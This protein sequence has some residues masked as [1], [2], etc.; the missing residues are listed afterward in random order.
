MDLILSLFMPELPLIRQQVRDHF[1]FFRHPHM[2]LMMRTM[3]L[4]SSTCRH[5]D[6]FI[7][8]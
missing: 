3:R 5:Q 6:L 1:Q 4:R 2:Y 8:V 7:H